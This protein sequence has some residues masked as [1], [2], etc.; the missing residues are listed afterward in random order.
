M[1]YKNFKNSLQKININQND[2]IMIYT[3]LS[4][5]SKGSWGE[6]CKLFYKYL[7][8]YFGKNGTILVPAFT[9]SFCKNQYFDNL[10]SKSEVGIFDE[11]FRN[12]VKVKRSYHPIFSF[13]LFGKIKDTFLENNSNSATGNGSIFEKFFSMDGKILFFGSRFINS[14]TFLHFIEQSN[15]IHYRY[16]KIFRGNIKINNKIYKDKDFEFFVRA[17]E[18]LKFLD[19]NKSTKIEKD[20]LKSKILKKITNNKFS[21]SMCESKKL[22]NFVEKKIKV[23]PNYIIDHKPEVI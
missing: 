8:K 10:K 3:D 17:T 21:I 11:Y 18:R 5:F 19:Y 16:S 13:S 9:Y 22:Y 14:C 7:D 2:L 12:Q 15:R 20:L 1:N 6:K 4:S 23:N